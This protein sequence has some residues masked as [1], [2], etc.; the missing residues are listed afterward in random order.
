MRLLLTS[1]PAL[2]PCRSGSDFTL[3]CPGVNSTGR[4]SSSLAGRAG[5]TRGRSLGAGGRQ[6]YPRHPEIQQRCH[7][8]CHEHSCLRGPAAPSPPAP[9]RARRRHHERALAARRALRPRARVDEAIASPPSP[10]RAASRAASACWCAWARP[11]GRCRAG[12]AAARPLGTRARR[13]PPAVV[14]AVVSVL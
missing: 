12:R 6:P 1:W 2:S 8:S 7:G 4:L 14:S 11:R 10:L 9:A 3:A 5:G 13:R